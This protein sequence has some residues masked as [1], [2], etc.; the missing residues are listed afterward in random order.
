MLVSLVRRL[1]HPIL[2]CAISIPTAVLA[3]GEGPLRQGL[4][5][6]EVVIHRAGLMAV[7]GLTEDHLEDRLRVQTVSQWVP[8]EV[9]TPG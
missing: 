6:D 7:E 9:D 4:P 2:V 5:A 8:C 1:H 3:R